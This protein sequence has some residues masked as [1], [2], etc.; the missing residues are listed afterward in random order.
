MR[1]MPPFLAIIV[2][3]MGC[4]QGPPP[5]QTAPVSG[6]AT[7][8]GKPLEE[9]RVY[10]FVPGSATQEA[11]TGN[12]GADG[13]FTLGVREE[14]GGAIVGLNEVWLVYDPVMPEVGPNE[15]VPMTP[16]PPPKVKIP[17]KYTSRDTSGITVEVPPEGLENY[18]LELE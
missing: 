9:Y 5:I 18:Q 2:M 15:P 11:A 8:Q 12:V 4:D 3:V 17:E 6:I 13:H 7:Y 16:P 10:F 1:W 14:G